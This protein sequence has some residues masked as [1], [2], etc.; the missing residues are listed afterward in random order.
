MTY[1]TNKLVGEGFI[2]RMNDLSDQRV[3]K[4]SITS[5]GIEYLNE[6]R[7]NKIEEAK[8]NLSNQYYDPKKLSNSIEYIK[9]FFSITYN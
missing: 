7:S 2:A 5:K 4:I 3:I 9:K 1:L 6:Y 8:R